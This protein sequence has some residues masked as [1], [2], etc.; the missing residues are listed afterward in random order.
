MIRKL[1]SA[2]TL[3]V[4]LVGTGDV[5]AQAGTEAAALNVFL[6]CNTWGCDFDHFRQEIGWVNWVRDR[7][8]ADVHL[9]ITGQETGG[10]GRQFELSYLGRGDFQDENVV[11]E[12]ATSANDTEDERRSALTRTIKLGLVRYAAATGVADRLDVS[13]DAPA[14]RVTQAAMTP[15]KDPWNAWVFNLGVSGSANGESLSRSYS[16]RGSLSASRVTADMKTSFRLSADYRDSE[17]KY[18]SVSD[19]DP[20]LRDT[21]VY[22]D[23]RRNYDASAYQVWSLSPH[24]ST[25]FETNASTST[26]LNQE[27]TFTA[28]PA[29]EYSVFPYSES[30]R[31]QLLVVY[32]VRTN[33]YDYEELT[34]YGHLS[35]R[36]ED[37][38]LRVSYN[39]TQP[40]GNAYISL[41]GH[42]YFH[43][44]ERYSVSIFGGGNLRIFRGLSLNLNGSAA[45]ISDQ[46]YVPLSSGSAADVL[47]QR[48]QLETSFRYHFNVGLSYR[49]G[50]SFN[51][52]VNPRL[53]SF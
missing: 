6:D 16:T 17:Y 11:L 4:C 20:A 32:A 33:Y 43:N 26:R 21:T 8:D 30:T 50:S 5:V 48:R 10:G 27:F 14:E 36:V 46:L 29:L 53:D 13:F 44:L 7:T 9:L 3:A 41:G 34:I 37:H 1:I 15:A 47:L 2:M 12:L 28:G 40:W 23:I 22:T 38:R 42:Q 49:F 52:V 24:W 45:K 18:I 51:N 31:R 35:Q 19:V 39:A 25:G